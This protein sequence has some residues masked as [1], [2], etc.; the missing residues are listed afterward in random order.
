MCYPIG[1]VLFTLEEGASYWSTT[2]T[3]RAFF[4]AM[5]TQLILNLLYSGFELGR[6]HSD[7]LFAFGLFDDF[8][9]YAT[10]ELFIFLLMG[11]AGGVMGAGYNEAT[12]RASVYR[13]NNVTKVWQRG[14]ELM[15]MTAIM[16]MLAF[17]LPLLWH[18]CTPVPTDTADWSDQELD[19]LDKLVRY[20]P[21]VLLF[22]LYTHP[23][24][25]HTHT[26]IE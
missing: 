25:T 22:L 8:S 16:A 24:P 7:G 2:L 20:F 3:F 19:L 21:A 6:D 5:I 14:V 13:M 15:L 11:A 10:F 26:P 18:T 4:C 17:L 12:R 23:P 1:G 9:G